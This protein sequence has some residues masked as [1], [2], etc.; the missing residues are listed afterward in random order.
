MKAIILAGGFGTRISEEVDNKPKPM[1]LRA[2][3]SSRFGEVSTL[4]C[5]R[6]LRSATTP[7]TRVTYKVSIFVIGSSK[8]SI[9]GETFQACLEVRGNI[10]L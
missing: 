5:G 2:H 6:Y 8:M 9:L 10:L 3:I 1:I 4:E 7:I